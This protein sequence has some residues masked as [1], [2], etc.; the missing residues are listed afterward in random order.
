MQRV[1]GVT[2]PARRKLPRSDVGMITSR[3]HEQGH[4]IIAASLAPPRW[5]TPLSRSPIHWLIERSLSSM[6]PCHTRRALGP[7][8]EMGPCCVL[9]TPAFRLPV[10]WRAGGGS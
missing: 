9:P 8:S 3:S 6:P 7:R 5:S 2:F 1:V 10:P 4:E